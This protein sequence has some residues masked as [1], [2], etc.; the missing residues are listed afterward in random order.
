MNDFVYTIDGIA[1]A[2][3]A[4]LVFFLECVLCCGFPAI[5]SSTFPPTCC[6]QSQFTVAS[7]VVPEV[8]LCSIEFPP[9]GLLG[10]RYSRISSVSAMPLSCR[11][12]L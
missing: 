10:V 8:I 4:Y 9:K 6:A 7:P 3:G 12:F 2:E 1:V 11:A 5:A